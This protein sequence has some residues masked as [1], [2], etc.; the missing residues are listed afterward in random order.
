MRYFVKRLFDIISSAAGLIVISPLLVVLAVLVRL[1]LGSP[2]LFCQ[3][4]PGLGGKAFVIYKFRTMTDQRDASGNLLPDSQ[5]LPA[6][7]QFLRSTSFDELPELLN[8][9]KGDMSIVGPRPLMMK[10][11]SRYTTEQARRHEVKPGITGW[12]QIN[13]R[14]AISW[15]DKFKLDVWYVD[16]WTLWLD[17]KIILKSVWMVATKQGITQ[18]GRAT[19]DEFMGTPQNDAVERPQR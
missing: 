9:L 14:N 6:F 16:N 10:Y 13:G 8:V 4:R 2:I 11:L 7:G 15:E 3:Q 19:M 18:Q 12:A 1:K 17:V 5:R